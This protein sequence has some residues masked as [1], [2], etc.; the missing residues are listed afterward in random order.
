VTDLHLDAADEL[1]AAVGFRITRIRRSRGLRQDDLARA[2]G[3][4]RTSIVNAETGRQRLPLD[5]LLAVAQALGVEL[6]DLIAVDR[7]MPVLAQPLPYGPRSMVAGALEEIESLR[8]RLEK[9]T[10]SLEP[11]TQ[12]GDPS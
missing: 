3:L 1:Y 8:A 9:V 11:L 10:Q 2:V 7:P 6:V 4:G 5:K 12:G